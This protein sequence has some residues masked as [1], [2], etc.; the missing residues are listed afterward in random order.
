[1]PCITSFAVHTCRVVSSRVG[2][3][4]ACM[5]VYVYALVASTS[6]GSTRTYVRCSFSPQ[7]STNERT[8][9]VENISSIGNVSNLIDRNTLA[10]RQRKIFN[11][12]EIEGDPAIH[13]RTTNATPRERRRIEESNASETRRTC[14]FFNLLATAR[15]FSRGICTEK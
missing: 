15:F 1:M 7:R 2:L 3:L 9:F 12:N 6:V 13:R 10:N 4:Y 14:F 11:G 8:M 5:C